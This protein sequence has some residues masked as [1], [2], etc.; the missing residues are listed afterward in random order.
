MAQRKKKIANHNIENKISSFVDIANINNDESSEEEYNIYVKSARQAES[1]TLDTET[2]SGVTEVKP[3]KPVKPPI[4]KRVPK[5]LDIK[6]LPI[7]PD[8]PDQYLTISNDKLFKM[9]DEYKNELSE[10]RNIILAQQK[11]TDIPL[12]NI[13]LANIPLDNSS[14]GIRREMMK[15]KFT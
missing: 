10:M 5:V 14:C 3:V 13:P 2:I 7:L 9:F 6:S 15:L 1:K 12:A 11:K 4:K 8:Q